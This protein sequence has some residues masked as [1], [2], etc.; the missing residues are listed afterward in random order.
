MAMLP[1]TSPSL[2]PTTYQPPP[3]TPVVRVRPSA[4]SEPTRRRVS[5][6]EYWENYYEN[7][8]HHYEWNNGYL[9]EKPMPDHV[10]YLMYDWLGVPK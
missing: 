5:E 4:T 2:R 6:T 10:S 7:S 3:T 1:Q 9:E 8:D